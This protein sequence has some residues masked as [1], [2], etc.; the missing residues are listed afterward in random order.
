MGAELRESEPV[1]A[2]LREQTGGGG[3]RRT[4]LWGEGEGGAV[5]AG[6]L[7]RG[8]EGRCSSVGGAVQ[9]VQVHG[10]DSQLLHP[11]SRLVQNLETDSETWRRGTEL[12][13][14]RS[15]IFK[16]ET[17]YTVT[18]TVIPVVC[19]KILYTATKLLL[20]QIFQVRFCLL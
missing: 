16:E 7:G 11:G 9:V 20:L 6:P 1:G 4:E 13:P 12:E 2:E 10:Q 18:N 17:F 8:I 15:N 5:R 3:A 19:H 14:N